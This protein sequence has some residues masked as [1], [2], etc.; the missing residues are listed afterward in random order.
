VEQGRIQRDDLVVLVGFGAGLTWAAT[1]IRWSAP[2]PVEPPPRQQKILFG[3]R[4]RY[5][6]VRSLVRRAVRRLL[7][8]FTR[9]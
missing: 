4:Y 2:L 6:A 8:L 5:A 1:A 9:E 7:A 3:L